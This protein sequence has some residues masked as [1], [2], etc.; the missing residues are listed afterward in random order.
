[1]N[2][3][4][5]K[6]YTFFFTTYRTIKQN[7]T[8]TLWKLKIDPIYVASLITSKCNDPVKALFCILFDPEIKLTMKHLADTCFSCS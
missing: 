7:D 5:A 3:T 8:D 1:M 2:A 6:T 4:Q